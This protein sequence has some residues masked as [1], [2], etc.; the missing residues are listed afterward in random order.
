ML[1]KYI[2]KSLLC[3]ASGLGFLWHLI[4]SVLR[5]NLIRGMMILESRGVS[6]EKGLHGLFRLSDY[7]YQVINERALALGHG[8]H[9]KHE[10]MRYADFFT[11]FIA[12]GWRVLDVG[13]SYGEV[14]RRVAIARPQATVLGIDYEQPKID[15]AKNLQNPP[16]LDF[17]LGDATVS[18][19]D[20][21]W[22]AL[23]LS[24]VLEHIHDRIGFLRA[25]ISTTGA[26]VFLIRVPFFDR[27]WQMPLRRQVGANY[28][29]DPDHK[30]EHTLDEFRAE[31][32]AAGLDLTHLETPW[33]EIWARAVPRETLR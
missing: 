21:G 3:T 22:D 14:A 20:G 13:C 28:Y 11:D 7:L 1:K 12:D 16:N 2:K 27:D 19:P 32:D 33:G 25:L 6:Q 15:M 8:V 4:P 9:P 18:V 23:I 10:L 26:Q 5:Q 17:V 24:N 31:L 30:I 29:S